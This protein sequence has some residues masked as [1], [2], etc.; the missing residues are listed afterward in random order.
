MVDGAV[1]HRNKRHQVDHKDTARM[2]AHIHHHNADSWWR[3][4]KH[5]EARVYAG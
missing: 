4:A 3:K 5:K 2:W 1:N